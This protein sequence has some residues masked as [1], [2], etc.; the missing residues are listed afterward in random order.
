MVVGTLGVEVY[1]VRFDVDQDILK[2]LLFIC[3]FLS[4][5]FRR[6]EFEF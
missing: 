2:A 5:V 3:L 6:W 4:F 1:L